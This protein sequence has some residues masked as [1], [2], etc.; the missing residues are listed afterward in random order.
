VDQRQNA[1]SGEQ[2]DESLQKLHEG[3]SAQS[4]QLAPVPIVRMWPVMQSAPKS[5]LDDT[6][7]RKK[8]LGSIYPIHGTVTF[9]HTRKAARMRVGGLILTA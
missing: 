6:C 1:E 7:L 2:D 5:F 8:L 4:L 3:D 9:G